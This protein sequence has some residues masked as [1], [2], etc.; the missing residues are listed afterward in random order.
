MPHDQ[1]FVE[2][3]GAHINTLE[4]G[5]DKKPKPK[6]ESTVI[7][8]PAPGDQK[9]VQHYRNEL[10][11]K[12]GESL[13]DRE[14]IPEYLDQTYE[15]ETTPV[16]DIIAKSAQKSGLRPELFY[17]SAMEEGMRGLFPTAANKGKI[18]YSGDEKNPISGF[19][20]FGLDRFADQ[21]PELVKQ[22]YL[23]KDFASNFKKSPGVNE[24]KEKVNSANFKDLS[25]A[26]QA[27]AAVVKY[28]Q[29]NLNKFASDKKIP[30]SQKANEFFTLV[31]YNSGEGNA[32]KMLEEYNKQGYLKDDKFLDKQP[33]KYWTA[34]YTNVK[35]RID[36]ANALKSEQYNF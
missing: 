27:K 25:S 15:N 1:N 12:Y 30:L 2:A 23:S 13:K 6:P 8:R 31:A 5:D 14:D 11:K 36:A 21:Y 24:K 28:T 17:A 33:S 35:K 26:V 34:P 3:V 16:K 4:G 29:D 7:P 32:R 19:V 22:G 9:S 20:N 10:H 18:D